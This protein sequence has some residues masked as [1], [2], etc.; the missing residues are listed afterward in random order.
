MRGVVAEMRFARLIVIAVAGAGILAAVVSGGDAVGVDRL[1]ASQPTGS[2]LNAPTLLAQKGPGGTDGTPTTAS[3]A[4]GANAPVD[5]CPRQFAPLRGTMP[6][7]TCVC[8]QE[9]SNPPSSEYV[10]GIDVYDDVSNVC[11]AARHAGVIGASGGT[12]TLIA[13]PGR[14]YYPG[15]PRNG[16]V[17]LDTGPQDG[18][19]RFERPPG[20]T[21]AASRSPAAP[22]IDPSTHQPVQ[23]PIAATLHAARR[24]EVYVNFVVDSAQIRPDAERV[25]QELLA[26]LRDDPALRVELVGH[27]D[28]T[29]GPVHNLDLSVRRA[30]SVQQWLVAHG[31]AANRLRSSGRG[32]T[33][34]IAA[35]DTAD[36]R[37]LNRRVEVRAV[38]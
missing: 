18:S 10:W 34:P 31:I 23:A 29:G 14:P 38:D 22:A 37:A 2:R 4:A 9:A 30:Q 27:T 33:E 5:E 19:I 36:G 21:A 11:L 35:N 20:Q 17:S 15:S 32:M 16:V 12:V 8:S 1:N 25:L 26:A 3:P 13:E 24:V 6:R 28:A 7:V